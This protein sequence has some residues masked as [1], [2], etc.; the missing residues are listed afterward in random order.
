MHEAFRDELIRR[1]SEMAGEESFARARAE[2]ADLPF[3]K[4]MA[5]AIASLGSPTQLRT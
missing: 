1:G 3:R 4:A 5:E 2:G